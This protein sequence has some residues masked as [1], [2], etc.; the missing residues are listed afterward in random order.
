MRNGTDNHSKIATLAAAVGLAL[1]SATTFAQAQ[2]PQGQTNRAAQEPT[3]VEQP[4]H[5]SSRHEDRSPRQQS[6]QRSSSG[7]M[8]L[9]ALAESR[10]DISSFVEA[11]QAAGMEDS[12]TAGTEYTIFAPTNKALDSMKGQDLDELLKP[13]N[14][15]D[16][17]SMLRAHIVADD[18][19]LETARTLTQAKTI[20]GGTVDIEVDDG[21]LMVGDAKIVDTEAVSLDNV[22]V[23]AI[24]DVL[25]AKGEGPF[26]FNRRDGRNERPNR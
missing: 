21:A 26:A 25:D 8:D 9:D 6:A 10:S 2:N 13:E 22:R 17:V 3:R 5:E 20:D 24:D 23:Y 16:L 12:L 4:R 1:G 11:L 19:D 15:E 18:L 7:G 14:R